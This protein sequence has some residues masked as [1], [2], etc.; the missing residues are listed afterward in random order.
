VI[1]ALVASRE[2]SV[3]D[4]ERPETGL[5]GDVQLP[6]ENIYGNYARLE[7]L[8][9]HLDRASDH[10]VELGCG[11][12]YMLTLPLRVWGYDVVGVDLDQTS[13]DYGRGVM[14]EAGITEDAVRCTDIADYED[15]LTVVIASEVLE[16]MPDDVLDSALATVRA[17][18]GPG[19]KLLVTIPNG[20]GWFEL[21]AA[22]WGK[23]GIG[24]LIE[25][26][27][28]D[29]VIWRLKHLVTGGYRDAVRPSTLADSPHVQRFTLAGIRARLERAGFEVVQA[30]GSALVC[31]PFSNL[32][33]TGF[34]RVMA[35]NVALG[36][37]WPPIAAGFQLVAVVR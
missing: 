17:K 29:A 33:F 3:V 9:S 27:R 15:P 24:R 8:R 1:R 5:A 4:L 18:L 23:L 6:R 25:W 14:R 22:L 28:L 32:L 20:Y 11:T 12:A 31:G 2:L 37:R 35:L 21:E 19:G 26:S 16:H 13:V 36:R 34:R 7:W 30:Q 10:A